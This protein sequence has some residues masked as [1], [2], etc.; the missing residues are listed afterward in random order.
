MPAN[1]YPQSGLISVG[2][3]GSRITGDISRSL[4]RLEACLQG[5]NMLD[6][7]S[8]LFIA[9]C[10]SLSRYLFSNARYHDF[11]YSYRRNPALEALHFLRDHVAHLV[12]K[13]APL[14]GLEAREEFQ[15]ALSG[16]FADFNN[17]LDETIITN[18]TAEKETRNVCQKLRDA[19]LS[20][21]FSQSQ[22]HD[23]AEAGAK[24]QRMITKIEQMAKSEGGQGFKFGWWG[25]FRSIKVDGKSYDVPGRIASLY[26]VLT[27]D[28][29]TNADKL[30]A[31]YT[32]SAYKEKSK[33]LFFRQPQEE[34]NEMI[35][36]FK[37]ELCADF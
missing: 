3:S 30:R 17:K 25:T 23:S 28:R 4:S 35:Q 11:Y 2:V 36:S 22:T 13:L 29:I 1:E 37:K 16:V 32:L 31:A 8:R 6:N 12:V 27:D 19:S 18:L 26:K 21:I 10:E 34:T 7:H 14:R 33:F 24:V 5:L 9:H 15:V 20:I